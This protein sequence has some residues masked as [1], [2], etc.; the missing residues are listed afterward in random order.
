MSDSKMFFENKYKSFKI[1]P[2][3]L[4]FVLGSLFGDVFLEIKDSF[5]L[6]EYRGKFKFSQVPGMKPPSALSHCGEYYYF[7]NKKTQKSICFQSGR[8]HGYEGLSPE[9]VVAPVVGPFKAGTSVFV[10]TNISGGLKKSL[11][12]ASVVAV[13]DHI[14]WTGSTPLCGL[15][16]KGTLGSGGS[17][18]PFQGEGSY[19]VDMEQA[20]HKKNTRAL[21]SL[22][23]KEGLCVTEGVYAGLL[24][25]ELETPAQVRML[26]E[27]GGDVVGM[28][29][30]WE[31]IALRYLKADVSVFSV[32]SN[33]A[34][35]V[36]E[37]VKINKSFLEP[38]LKAVVKSLFVFAGQGG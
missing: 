10:L 27:T 26:R 1:P 35:G 28:S 32:V 31:V 21:K 19:F 5:S 7:Q 33:P 20:Y 13:T 3:H 12:V 37:S 30:L 6:W 36:G 22:M 34:C 2:P 25:P 11:P 17:V 15:S 4:H 18:I 16:R 8:L 23:Q 38:S 24:G 14:N 9:E 29:T